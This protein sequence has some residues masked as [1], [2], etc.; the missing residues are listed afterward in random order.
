MTEYLNIDAPRVSRDAALELMVHHL[1]LAHSYFQCTIDDADA[2]RDE[3]HR[4]F[5]EACGTVSRWKDDG[6]LGYME[7]VKYGTNAPEIVAGMEWLA[8]MEEIYEEMKSRD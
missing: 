5:T 3:A 4:L 8:K 1:Q 7:N 2:K 6:G